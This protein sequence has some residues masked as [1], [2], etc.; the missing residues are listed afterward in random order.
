MS[1]EKNEKEEQTYSSARELFEHNQ[2]EIIKRKEGYYDKVID[3]LHL[4]TGKLDILIVLLI[5]I[6]II[7]FVLGSRK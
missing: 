3:S 1:E 2:Q 4:T 5:A 6:I 7:I